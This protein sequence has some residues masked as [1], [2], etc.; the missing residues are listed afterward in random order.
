MCDFESATM[1]DVGALIDAE[2]KAA[3]HELHEAINAAIASGSAPEATID[4]LRGPFAD[5]LKRDGWLPA[6]CRVPIPGKAASYALL[7]SKDPEYVLFSMVLPA[8]E[9]TK[10]HNHLAWG[11]IGLWQGTQF[12]VQYRRVDDGANP[13]YAELQETERRRL[14]RGEIT[15]LLPPVDD[16]H[17]ISTLSDTPSISIHLLGNDLGKIRRQL[18]YPE[19]KRAETFISGYDNVGGIAGADA[20]G[21][22]ARR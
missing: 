20:A 11:L 16:I 2:G 18:F 8:G 3:L 19:E 5:F 21:V 22:G 17:I 14:D 1:P 6:P 15:R 9:S 4:R 7:R 10:V 13:D 12:E